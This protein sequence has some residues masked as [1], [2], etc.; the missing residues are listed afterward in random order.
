M[1]TNTRLASEDKKLPQE[2]ALKVLD[3][4]DEYKWHYAPLF[5][6]CYEREEMEAHLKANPDAALSLV[7][8][9]DPDCAD[10]IDISVSNDT[11]LLE[12]EDNCNYL[13]EKINSLDELKE[14][15]LN[16]LKAYHKQA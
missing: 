5:D 7:I 11:I 12:L 2:M 8:N 1:T 16:M 3:L 9:Y 4:A 6:G 14:T 10:S 15:A 13:H